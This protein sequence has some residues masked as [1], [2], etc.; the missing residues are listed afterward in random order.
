MLLLDCVQL[1]CNAERALS[2][3]EVVEASWPGVR[4]CQNPTQSKRQG[5]EDDVDTLSPAWRG[6]KSEQMRGGT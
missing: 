1:Q 4:P 6:R 5:S 2:V 3:G